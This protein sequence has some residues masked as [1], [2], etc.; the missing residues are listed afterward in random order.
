[1]NFSD[2]VD[3]DFDMSWVIGAERFKSKHKTAA[4]IGPTDP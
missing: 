1:M 4:T 3:S 2:L